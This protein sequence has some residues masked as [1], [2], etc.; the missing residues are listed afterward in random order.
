V[1]ELTDK[2]RLKKRDWY[3]YLFIAPFF[4]VYTIFHLMP[5]LNTIFLSFTDLW[6]FNTEY[7]FVGFKNYIDILHNELFFKAFI[8]TLIVWGMNYLPQIGLALF[9]AALFVSNHDK[10][11]GEG[12]FKVLFYMPNIITAASI[13]ILFISLFASP[14]GS[15]NLLLVDLGILKEPFNFYR[16]VTV[17]RIIVAFIGFWMW[18]GKTMIILLAGMKGINPNLYEAAEI[19]GANN[20]KKFTKITLPLLKPI[21]L[22]VFITN[23]AGG[24][25][26][27]DIPFLLTDG[28]PNYAVETISMFIYKQA[29]TGSQNFYLAS[30]ASVYLLM[31]VSLV[32]FV[33]FKLFDDKEKEGK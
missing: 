14:N 9:L 12:M 30:T 21:L 15:I 10:I 11:R 22:F 4:I 2:T 1:S 28:G 32:T 23:F 13:A 24:M 18:Y 3:G 8:N 26:M 16:D 27:F 7:T 33:L 31:F 20:R 6:G 25:R 29:F 19:D 17:T 5:I